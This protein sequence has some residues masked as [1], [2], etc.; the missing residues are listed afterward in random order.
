[1]ANLKTDVV[2]PID[3]NIRRQ[4]LLPLLPY[5]SPYLPLPS[6]QK[7]ADNTRFVVV[8]QEEREGDK[9]EENDEDE[10]KSKM[11]RKKIFTSIKLPSKER[12]KSLEQY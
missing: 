11:T 3:R 10:E 12:M 2:N 7:E 6:N 1:M 8:K 5:I 4:T 9:E